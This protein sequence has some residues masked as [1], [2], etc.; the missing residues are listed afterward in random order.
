MCITLVK[1]SFREQVSFI[2][3]EKTIKSVRDQSNYSLKQE[4]AN[5]IKM[6]ELLDIA[7]AGTSYAQVK[8]KDC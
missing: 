5:A 2:F 7:K 3:P 8:K 1:S 4:Q 6:D